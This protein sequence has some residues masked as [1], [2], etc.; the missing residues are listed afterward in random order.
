MCVLASDD[1]AGDCEAFAASGVPVLDGPTQAPWGTTA[2][3]ADLYGNPYYLVQGSA[4][5]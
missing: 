3:I 2:T 5:G 1:V 4:P